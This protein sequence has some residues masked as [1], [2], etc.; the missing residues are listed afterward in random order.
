MSMLADVSGTEEDRGKGGTPKGQNTLQVCRLA[1]GEEPH[2]CHLM[3]MKAIRKDDPQMVSSRV[4]RVLR[5]VRGTPACIFEQKDYPE[6]RIMSILQVQE[7][8]L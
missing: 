5:G 8:P 1:W 3:Q 6:E 4:F 7:L 2:D